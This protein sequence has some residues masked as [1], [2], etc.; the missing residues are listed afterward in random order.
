MD[1][2]TT[3]CG[4]VGA[5]ISVGVLTMSTM[6]RRVKRRPPLGGKRKAWKSEGQISSEVKTTQTLMPPRSGDIIVL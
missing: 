2:L 6:S 5:A 4:T 3:L 1:P